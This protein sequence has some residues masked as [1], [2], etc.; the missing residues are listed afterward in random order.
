MSLDLERLQKN[1]DRLINNKAFT[2]GEGSTY[3]QAALIIGNMQVGEFDTIN[4]VTDKAGD[5]PR[6]MNVL[7]QVADEIGGTFKK[8]DFRKLLYHFEGKKTLINFVPSSV[9]GALRGLKN[10]NTFEMY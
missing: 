3:T 5:I 7:A 2:R 4:V 8:A 9:R 6:L 10:Y 1:Y